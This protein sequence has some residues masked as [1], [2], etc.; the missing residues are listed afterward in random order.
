MQKCI[1]EWSNGHG[2]L[3]G[4]HL[5]TVH[6][7]I[8]LFLY[9]MPQRHLANCILHWPELWAILW[10]RHDQKPL[11]TGTV[12]HC[13]MHVRCVVSQKVVPN[14]NTMVIGS[15]NLISFNNIANQLTKIPKNICLCPPQLYAPN[16]LAGTLDA[17][18]NLQG[19]IRI[20]WFNSKECN[21]FLTVAVMDMNNLQR[22]TR[23]AIGPLKHPP[24]LSRLMSFRQ[25]TSKI[26][27]R[28]G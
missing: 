1:F 14:K 28:G 25:G 17:P 12:C 7:P 13:L 5:E 23:G 20:S 19:Q 11:Q 16:P 22:P 6:V 2:N 26:P 18:V 10:P 27:R 21:D 3:G 24:I 4:L 9:P 8:C 15:I